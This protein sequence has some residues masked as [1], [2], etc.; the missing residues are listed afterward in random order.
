MQAMSAIKIKQRR[1]T[2]L[3]RWMGFHAG[4]VSNQ[5][6]AE[7]AHK[8]HSLDGNSCRHCQQ[9]K[10]PREGPHSSLPGWDFMQ[11]MSAIKIEQRRPTQLTRWMGIHAGNVRVTNQLDNLLVTSY[12]HYSDI[13]L[14]LIQCL[15]LFP[16][17]LPIS[18]LSD[19]LIIT[20]TY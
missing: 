16:W 18:K 10:S 20:P 12:R 19:A 5:N 9:S 1:P 2:Q 8:T 14:L 15:P 13:D 6:Q 3:T 11:A 7:K 4:N 17:K